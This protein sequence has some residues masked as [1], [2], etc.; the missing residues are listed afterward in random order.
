M[1]KLVMLLLCVSV[2]MWGYIVT[3]VGAKRVEF[4][5]D[6]GRHRTPLNVLNRE[7]E[8]IELSTWD[9]Q[10]RMRKPVEKDLNFTDVENLGSPFTLCV[11][12]ADKDPITV[13]WLIDKGG[14][15]EAAYKAREA[16]LNASIEE[17]KKKF[18]QERD[19]QIKAL[20]D[21]AVKGAAESER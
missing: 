20:V 17:Q 18:A 10:L 8:Y 14:V 12:N 16:G 5:V 11:I 1:K 15:L 19:K 21:A 2:Q 9:K 13:S 3:K 6:K 4:F 7:G